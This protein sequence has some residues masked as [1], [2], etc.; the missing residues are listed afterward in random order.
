MSK[1]KLVKIIKLKCTAEFPNK[2]L[3]YIK[4]KQLFLLKL[5]CHLFITSICNYKFVMMLW[6]TA[7][8]IYELNHN[9]E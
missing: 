4:V 8:K 3:H 1:F 9:T 2:H 6:S 7:C 5:E